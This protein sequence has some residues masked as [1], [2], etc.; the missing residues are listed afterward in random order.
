MS[1]GLDSPTVAIAMMDVMAE[2]NGGDR[3]PLKGFVSVPHDEWD[4]RDRHGKIGDESG[5]VRKLMERYP[6]LDVEFVDS[7]GLP[8]DYG[9]DDVHAYAEQPMR[10]VGNLH[11]S[12][13]ISE[14]CYRSGRR[15][16]LNGS[17]GNGTFSLQCGIILIRQ[18]F[19]GGRWLHLLHEYRKF[20]AN[21]PGMNGGPYK[22]LFGNTVV[23]LFPDW[24]YD[25]Y[26]TL[27]GKNGTTGFADY[28]PIN[29]GYA[30]D[31]QV[32]QR[33]SE[34]GWDDRFR[35]L[36]SR[37]DLMRQLNQNGLRSCSSA[38]TEASRVI[39]RVD[40]RDPM[41]DRKI[42]EFCYAIP[43][44]QFYKDGVDRRLIKRMMAGRLPQEILK[45]P[46]G[47]QGADWHSRM[48]P[49][50]QRFDAELTRL[51][52]DPVMAERLDIQRMRDAIRNWPDKTPV[53]RADNPEMM[54]MRL[55]IPRAISVARFINRVEGKNY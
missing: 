51:A 4:G 15:V 3:E 13:D 24:L 45:A 41:G 36:Q 30:R 34:H 10:G 11:W 53:S 38:F 21:Q 20:T 27:R 16:M 7:A 5:P 9:L 49:D 37:R 31:M 2:E 8:I 19:S 48:V 42:V 47:D 33:M 6:Q 46:R 1:A 17:S 28:S 52:D 40:S 22:G 29:E 26:I 55:G 14:R 50:L 12:R 39:N 44:D 18:W 43:D 32:S 54:I 25:K 23:P 35:V